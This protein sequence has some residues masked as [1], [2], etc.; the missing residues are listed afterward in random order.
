MTSVHSAKIKTRPNTAAGPQAVGESVVS[1]TQGSWLNQISGVQDRVRLG[2]V[3]T[4]GALLPDACLKILNPE[5]WFSQGPP[6]RFGTT[7]N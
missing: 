4:T 1:K 6:W 7:I 5:I 3:L 2:A